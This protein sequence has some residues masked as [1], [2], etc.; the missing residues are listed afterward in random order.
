M[1]I[2]KTALLWG[3]VFGI[4][5]AILTLVVSIYSSS[6]EVVALACV[7]LLLSFALTIA[8]SA[9]A[10]IQARTFTIGFLAGVIATGYDLIASLLGYVV[11]DP[12]MLDVDMAATIFSFAIS[13]GAGLILSAVGAGIGVS[14][15]K[16]QAP[17]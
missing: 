4:L 14:I 5:Q 6:P 15:A 13:I 7:G 2:M 8:C 17:R 12:R 9:I 10:T 3:T 11:I 16:P 1:K